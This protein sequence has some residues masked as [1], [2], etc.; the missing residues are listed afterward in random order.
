M[1]LVVTLEQFF[2]KHYHILNSWITEKWFL[3][4]SS[5]NS[6]KERNIYTFY[7][8]E[9]SIFLY[10]ILFIML[11]LTQRWF[12]LHLQRCPRGE[13]NTQW[14]SQELRTPNVEKMSMYVSAGASVRGQSGWN[15]VDS[16]NFY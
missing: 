14:V 2:L 8:R 7:I 3:S 11:L 1:Y 6:Q 4:G 12:P 9:P 5:H 15:A 13:Q 10:S 16:L